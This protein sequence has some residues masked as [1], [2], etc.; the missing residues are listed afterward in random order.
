MDKQ[1]GQTE[2]FFI[3]F[4]FISMFMFTFTQHVHG[5]EI[6]S[7]DMQHDIQHEDL[8]MKNGNAAGTCSMETWTWS[9]A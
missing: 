9:M 2:F 6:Y 1:H 7:V 4:V 5:A 3:M 8:D